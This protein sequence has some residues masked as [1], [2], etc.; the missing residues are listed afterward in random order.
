MRDPH[1]LREY[2]VYDILTHALLACDIARQW[3]V[4][5]RGR[6]V[7]AFRVAEDDGVPVR[8]WM[9]TIGEAASN[10]ELLAITPTRPSTA[11]I[12]GMFSGSFK[13]K[14]IRRLTKDVDAP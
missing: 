13:H 3:P 8:R 14:D 9:W 10:S 4:R 12:A 7:R 6:G 5:S 2:L 11:R 1:A